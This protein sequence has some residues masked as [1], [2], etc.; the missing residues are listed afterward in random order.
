M[1][2]NKI[3]GKR[4]CLGEDPN[5]KQVAFFNA[6][7]RH[8]GYGGARG[9]GKSWA[10]RTLCVILAGTYP[11]LKILLLR[12]TLPELYENHVRPLMEILN[13]VAEYNEGKKLFKFP[14]G[15]I[16]K[17]GYCDAEKDVYQYQGQ[18]YDVVCLEEA[19]HF[20]ESQRDFLTTCNRSIR[21]D[22]KPVMYYTCNPG[23]VGHAWVKRLFIDREYRGKEKP[24]DYV[25][26]PASVFD[27]HVLMRNNPE[28]VDTLANLP[29]DLRKAHLEGDWNVLAGQYFKE[30]RQNRH[31]VEPFQIPENWRRFRSMDWGFNDPCAVLWY[32]VA[33]DGRVYVYREL[34]TQEMLARDVARKVLELSAGESIAYTTASPDAW[35]KRGLQDI[36]GESIAETFAVNG[37]PLIRADNSRIIGWQRVHEYLADMPDGRPKVQIFSTCT[38]LIKTLPLMIHDERNVEDVADGLPDHWAESLRYGLMSRPTAER[39]KPEKKKYVYDPFAKS[40]PRKNTWG[41]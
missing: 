20:T 28:Y 36:D 24:E 22:F 3:K 19:T 34:T 39:E 37:V 7:G 23:G 2:K 29:E 10:V 5:P 30:W 8:I 41:F 38:D 6:K 17:L 18:E 40:T 32:A 13:G 9:G 25:F 21:S 11:G 27:N 16:I 4:V 14:N 33:P 15:S 31:V 1:R 35:Q 12:R 26:I